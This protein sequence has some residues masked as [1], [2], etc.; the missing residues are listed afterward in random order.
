MKKNMIQSMRESMRESMRKSTTK[1]SLMRIISKALRLSVIGMISNQSMS[2]KSQ[3][4]QKALLNHGKQSK[5]M[6]LFIERQIK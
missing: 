1:E 3:N 2:K 5:K 4:S 6:I